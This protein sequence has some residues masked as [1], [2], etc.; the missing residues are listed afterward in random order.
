MNPED[1]LNDSGVFIG[2]KPVVDDATVSYGP[3]RLSVAPKANTLLADH[4][5]SPALFLA[6]RLER[7]LIDVRDRRIVE[8]G[9]GTGLPSLLSVL[10]PAPPQIV[11]VTD[12]PDE[13]IMSN[14]RQNVERN[15]HLFPSTTVVQCAEYAWG[16]DATS[17]RRFLSASSDGF[18][19]VFLS[20]L[21]HFKDSH[22][23][24][25]AS[26]LSLLSKTP[27]AR[28]FVSAGNY[29][30]AHICDTFV[31]KAAAANLMMGEVPPGENFNVWLG[32]NA[33]N[34]LDRDALGLRKSVCR[35]WIGR[36]ARL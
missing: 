27:D 3:L 36:W 9:A 1:I 31:S 15:R 18:D 2:R 28:V 25:I 11:V 20:D 26:V 6:E 33:V 32:K 13:R 30:K 19:V 23:D 21:L 8:L 35:F 5:F 29:T 4:L 12:Y 16:T 14:L 34:G 22:D 7:G 10:L 17:L 24:L